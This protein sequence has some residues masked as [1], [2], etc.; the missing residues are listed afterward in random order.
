MKRFFNNLRIKTASRFSFFLL[1]AAVAVA[2]PFT[3][4]ATVT[5]PDI[6]GM[7][8][9]YW[10]PIVSCTGNYPIGTG[11]TPPAGSLPNCTNLD[12]L[13]QTVVN[14][15]YLVMSAGLFII[16]P[17]LFIIGGIMM[18]ISSGNP[19][20]IGKAR[21]TMIGAVVGLVIVLCSYLIVNTV[22]SVFHITGV[23]GFGS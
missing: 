5:A 9:G 6:W 15:I 4:S 13:L 12:D 17:I 1:S 18:I 3:A 10:G 16:A 22:I 23:A 21:S 19:E 11:T 14:A 8:P 20:K 7:P 2:I